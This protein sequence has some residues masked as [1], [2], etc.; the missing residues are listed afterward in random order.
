MNNNNNSHS[1]FQ[2]LIKQVKKE[3]K[4]MLSDEYHGLEVCS[5]PV[6]PNRYLKGKQDEVYAAEQKIHQEE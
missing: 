4:K 6:S 2:H 1:E 5:T 3:R